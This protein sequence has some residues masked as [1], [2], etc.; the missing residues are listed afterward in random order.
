MEEE[1]VNTD[2]REEVLDKVGVLVLSTEA[3]VH[4]E[5]GLTLR[6]RLRM[7]QRERW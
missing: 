4:K 7:K 2:S 5:R 6:T 3:F 1:M